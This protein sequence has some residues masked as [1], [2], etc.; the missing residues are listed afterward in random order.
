MQNIKGTWDWV[1]ESNQH[2]QNMGGG[3]VMTEMHFL[4]AAKLFLSTHREEWVIRKAVEIH[5]ET[6]ALTREDGMKLSH[7]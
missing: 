4:E 6:E 1:I 7:A 3:W 2:W 5:L